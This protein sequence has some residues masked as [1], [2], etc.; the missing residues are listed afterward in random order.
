M[1]TRHYARQMPKSSLTHGKTIRLGNTGSVAFVD[2]NDYE[3]ARRAAWTRCDGYPV[4][5]VSKA[6]RRSNQRL[7]H[8]ILDVPRRTYV[9]HINGDPFDCRRANLKVVRGCIAINRRSKRAPFRVKVGMLNYQIMLGSYP[10]RTMAE[11]ILELAVSAKERMLQIVEAERWTKKRISM[12]LRRVVGLDFQD[13][14]E[15]VA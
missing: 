14:R 4:R 2:S 6:G 15:R 7:T 5:Q 3:R 1:L 9:R 12:Y 8:F 10:T 13:E 11:E